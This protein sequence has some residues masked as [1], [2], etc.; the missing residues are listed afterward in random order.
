MYKADKMLCFSV[1]GIGFT[2]GKVVKTYSGCSMPISKIN[3]PAIIVTAR[4]RL[5][6]CSLYP[7][8]AQAI[9]LFKTPNKPPGNP[10]K[11]KRK[12]PAAAHPGG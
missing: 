2:P 12:A 7:H 11:P 6:L 10:T 1:N 3:I 8:L 4:Y 9:L 5:P